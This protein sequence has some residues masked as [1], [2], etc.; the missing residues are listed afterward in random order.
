VRTVPVQKLRVKDFNCYC[1]CCCCCYWWCCFLLIVIVVVIILF[2]L[3]GGGGD[4]GVCVFEERCNTEDFF[5]LEK[6]IRE[7]SC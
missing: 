6:Y 7:K 4:G 5:I 3:L 1:C 2:L